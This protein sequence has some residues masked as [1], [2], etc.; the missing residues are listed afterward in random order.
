MPLRRPPLGLEPDPV[1]VGDARSWVTE[2]LT[3]LGRDDLVD[4]AQLGVSE[5]VTN[6]V[7]H[8]A[9]PISVSV[10]GTRDHPRIEVHDASDEPPQVRPDVTEADALLS[11]FGR[12]ISIVA[13]FSAR[14]GADLSGEGKTVWFEPVVDPQDAPVAGDLFDISAAVAARLAVAPD[15][16]QVQVR[17][18][19]LPVPVFAGL[20]THYD[21]LCREL[22]LLALAH[23]GAYPVADALTETVLQ[24]EQERRQTRGTQ[25]VDEAIRLGCDRVDLTYDVPAT[26]PA[27]MAR[28]LGLLDAAET[29]CLQERMLSTAATP[30]Q[31]ALQRWYL[32]E[33]VRQGA[34]EAPTAWP[35][36]PGA[37]GQ[38]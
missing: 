23:G 15:P 21:E 12:G 1:S 13:S 30:E 3:A 19:G 33:F 10:R 22:R 2:I 24:V 5:L 16:G 17:L 28:L 35:G 6:A 4:A 34:G 11:T 29:F 26:A 36:M 31:R 14:W 25:A 7:L 27:T 32:T 9:P 8:A 20:R 18:L 38:P 37:G